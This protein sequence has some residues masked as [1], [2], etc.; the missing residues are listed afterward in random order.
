[1]KDDPQPMH[2]H[3][4]D[5]ALQAQIVRL[6]RDGHEHV[7]LRAYDAAVDRYDQALAL[8]PH[9]VKRWKA[10]LGLQVAKADALFRAGRFVEV[11]ETLRGAIESSRAF[12]NP[13][14]HLRLGQALLECG[15]RREAAD[16]LAGAYL[17]GGRELFA[18]DDPKYRQFIEAVLRPPSGFATWD[19]AHQAGWRSF[20][21]E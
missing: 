12:S 3:V 1:M 2:Q 6:L 7:R 13:Y 14:L 16:W 8:L 15:E 10:T 4:L 17:S 18:S 20:E 19:E 9:P 21:Y 11:C 5:D